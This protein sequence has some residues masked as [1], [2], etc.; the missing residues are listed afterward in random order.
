MLFSFFLVVLDGRPLLY[1][2]HEDNL[3]SY[4]WP[5]GTA[6]LGYVPIGVG[7]VGSALTAALTQDR[8]YK[9]LSRRFGTRGLP[10]YRLV[11]TQVSHY[12]SPAVLEPQLTV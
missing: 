10:E 6:G 11:L 9:H 4:N 2:R 1:S 12:A 7:F 8:I 5:A 3:F